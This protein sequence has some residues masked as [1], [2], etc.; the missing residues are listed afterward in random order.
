MMSVVNI[1]IHVIRLYGT[2]EVWTV[3]EFDASV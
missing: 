3:T 2:L 1:E